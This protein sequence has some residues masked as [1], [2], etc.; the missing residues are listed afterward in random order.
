[1]LCTYRKRQMEE[2]CVWLLVG[3]I[4]QCFLSTDRIR[5]LNFCYSKLPISFLHQYWLYFTLPSSLVMVYTPITAL[6]CRDE[7]DKFFLF[8]YFGWIKMA[9]SH[10]KCR[11]KKAP[12]NNKTDANKTCAICNKYIQKESESRKLFSDSPWCRIRGSI[13]YFCKLTRMLLFCIRVFW[14]LQQILKG[15]FFVVNLV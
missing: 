12:K 14:L 1:M 2:C 5:N 10:Y 6:C 15:L 7:L 3:L 8:V 11:F 4:T 13:L 9:N